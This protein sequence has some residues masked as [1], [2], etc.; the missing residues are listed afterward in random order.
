MAGVGFRLGF[1]AP[2]VF[3]GMIVLGT[4][5]FALIGWP[6]LRWIGRR[7]ERKLL[8]DQSIML[9]SL[10]LI[11]AIV[12]SIGLAFEAPPWI[13]TGM[14]AFAG[15]KTAATLLFAWSAAGR[16]ASEP[17]SLLLL[18]V[19]ALGKRSELLFEKLR[20]HW[21]HVGNISMIA[22]PDLVTINVEPH[23]FLEFLSGRIARQ[24]VSGA[25]DLEQRIGV[26]DRSRD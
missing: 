20:T 23:E 21:L 4:L 8:S 13:L 15:Y 12:G 11:F 22:G 17:R 5:L 26:V 2:V 25:Q 9:D 16:A 14:A 3:G 24:F 7:Y 1:G 6:M 10:W 19:F 18:R